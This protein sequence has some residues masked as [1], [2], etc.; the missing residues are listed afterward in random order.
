MK[1]EKRGGILLNL[2]LF[3]LYEGGGSTCFLLSRIES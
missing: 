3:R 1:S 2:R